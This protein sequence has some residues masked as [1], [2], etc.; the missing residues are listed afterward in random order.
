MD[1]SE[2]SAS[3]I[4]Q[5]SNVSEGNGDLPGSVRAKGNYQT[6]DPAQANSGIDTPS[7]Q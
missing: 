3:V 5:Q 6:T 2:V 1:T 4:L 7:Q